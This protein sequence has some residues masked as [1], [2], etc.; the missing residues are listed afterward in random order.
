M[1]F[2]FPLGT[3]RSDGF[4]RAAVDCD[5]AGSAGMAWCDA[6]TAFALRTP[7]L[8]VRTGHDASLSERDPGLGNQAGEHGQQHR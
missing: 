7:N 1:Q 5:S 2:R 6:V 8:P 3:G 4:M